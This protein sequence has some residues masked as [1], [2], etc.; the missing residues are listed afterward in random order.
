VT[1]LKQSA[2]ASFIRAPALHTKAVLVY[3]PDSGRV[4]EVAKQIVRSV[5][6][7]HDDPF[8]VVTVSDTSLAGDPALLVDEARSLSLLGGRRVVWIA[9][10][11]RGFQAAMEAYLTDPGGDALIVAEAGALPKSSKL[12]S[13]FEQSK[14]VALIAC[15]EDSA[16]ELRALVCRA[17][18][19]A[20]LAIAD[21]AVEYLIDRIGSDRAV[22][23]REVEKLLLYCHGRASIEVS[24][25]EAICG[26]VSA[27]S[28]DGL[29]D[30][31]FAGDVT[32]CCRRF[33]Q[34]ADSGVSASAVLGTTGNYL[35]KMQE[36]RSEVARG[37]S[38]DAVVRGAR[39]P[40][41]F[42]RHQSMARQLALWSDPALDAA[43]RT[44]LDATALTRQFASLDHAVCERAILSLARRAQDMRA[45]SGG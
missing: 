37:R 29:L 41:H 19:E 44:V 34:L 25:V 15:Y 40:I 9:P 32:E 7:S 21:D 17:A 39:P 6:G 45:K 12:R 11:G 26:D 18:S 5:A 42:S 43:L 3:G 10:A 24:D 23:R 16:E 13:L 33:S 28:L 31:T 35:A 38:P 22:S 8:L 2:S 30:A 20:R 14:Q 1:V 36:L 27:A 4:H